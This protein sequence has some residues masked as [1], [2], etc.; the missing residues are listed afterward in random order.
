MRNDSD[1][2][3]SSDSGSVDQAVA[4]P[5]I[6]CTFIIGRLRFM[7]S[8]IRKLK[9]LGCKAHYRPRGPIRRYD[10]G[11]TPNFLV[12]H[13]KQECLTRVMESLLRRAGSVVSDISSC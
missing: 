10:D 1:I 5:S 2:G 6:A 9:E 13:P 3:R 8:G 4:T 12:K 7:L 11:S